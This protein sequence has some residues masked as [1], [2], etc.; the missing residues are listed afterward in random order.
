MKRSWQ[1]SAKWYGERVSELFIDAEK[2]KALHPDLTDEMA[3]TSAQSMSLALIFNKLSEQLDGRPA[4]RHSDM[5]Q[6][7]KGT[8]MATREA[9]SCVSLALG[10]S[11]GAIIEEAQSR[12]WE[13]PQ[14]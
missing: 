8:R 14:D 2:V 7:L 9:L 4:I 5:L 6:V 11:S 12:Q 10:T 1:P 3:T 13:H